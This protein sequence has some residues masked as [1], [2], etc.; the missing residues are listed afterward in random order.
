MPRPSEMLLWWFGVYPD[1][2]IS[3]NAP[4]MSQ[5]VA[6]LGVVPKSLTN[7]SPYLSEWR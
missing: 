6:I 2:C 5:Q 4:I 1:I 3:N 7:T